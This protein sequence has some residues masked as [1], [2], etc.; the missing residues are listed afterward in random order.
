MPLTLAH[1]AAAVPLA[2]PLG[3]WGVLPAL[4][5]GSIAPDLVYFLPVRITREQSHSVSGLFWWCLPAGVALFVLYQIVLRRPLRDLM[6]DE[7]Q[8]RLA[9]APT[10]ASAIGLVAVP[11]SVLVGSVTHLLWDSFTHPEAPAVAAFPFLRWRLFTIS[12]YPVCVFNVLQH[13]S[14]AVG[15]LLLV[16]WIRAWVA[17]TEPR[18]LRPMFPPATR[19]AIAGG[20]VAAASL[21]ALVVGRRYLPAQVTLHGLQPFAWH[22]VTTG[23][24]SIGAGIV[25]YSV[26]W[27]LLPGRASSGR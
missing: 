16:R 6:P 12:D 24:G 25:L 2:R 7:W 9:A 1:P 18:P 21:A 10:A 17:R 13:T 11:I 23:L 20:I 15:I 8:A 26:A 4:V 14:T 22:L 3:R 5:I 27:H 19:W